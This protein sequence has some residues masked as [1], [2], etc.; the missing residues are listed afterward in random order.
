LG[1][2]L[3]VEQRRIDEWFFESFFEDVR[4][5]FLQG[6]CV[7]FIHLC[8]IDGFAVLHREQAV[9]LLWLVDFPPIVKDDVFEMLQEEF[10]IVLDELF[11]DLMFDC[12]EEILFLQFGLYLLGDFAFSLG[13]LSF[14][15]VVA[16]LRFHASFFL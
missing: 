8:L 2:L 1:V 16:R 3:D 12:F 9:G 13:P 10:E 4:V 15:E 6:V 5:D 11:L 14:G 7:F